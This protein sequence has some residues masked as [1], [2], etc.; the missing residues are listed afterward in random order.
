MRDL[1]TY[2][3]KTVLVEDFSEITDML[4]DIRHRVTSKQVFI[5]GAYEPNATSAATS[6]EY[7]QKIAQWLIEEGYHIHTGYGKGIGAE[8]V[9]GAFAGCKKRGTKIKDFN[10]AVFLYPFPYQKSMTDEERKA[11]YPELR[12]NTI[13]KTH[14]TIVINGTKQ[15]NK[16]SATI[17][18][19]GV[20]E[21][22]H[23]SMEQGNVIIP[24]AVTGGASEVLWTEIN[25]TNSPYAQTDDFQI[26]AKGTSVEDVIRAVKNIVTAASTP[27]SL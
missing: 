3:I 7:A 14:I 17:P 8:I 16:R 13:I 4:R 19:P 9:A 24:I 18:S 1:Q 25:D 23:L 12:K 20:M 27:T 5:S 11:I 26:L 2:G 22:C 15:K 6:A 10:N 21:E